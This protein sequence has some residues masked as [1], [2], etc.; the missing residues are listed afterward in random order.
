MGQTARQW[1]GEQF[2]VIIVQ[3]AVTAPSGEGVVS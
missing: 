2:L 3:I 1:S